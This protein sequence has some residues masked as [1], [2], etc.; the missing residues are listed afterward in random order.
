MNQIVVAVRKRFG[1]HTATF[2][3]LLSVLQFHIPFY[4]GRTLPN[5]TALP[6]VNLSIAYVL[7]EEYWRGVALLTAAATVVRLELALMVVPLAINLVVLKRM[8]FTAALTAGLAGGFGSLG[9]FKPVCIRR[10]V[11]YSRQPS[12]PPS[13]TPCGPPLFRTP[14]FRTLRPRTPSGPSSAR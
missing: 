6:L 7:H 10:S 2:F 11:A 8:S 14:A 4:A 13:T 1:N 12:P 9:K 5:F 3:V